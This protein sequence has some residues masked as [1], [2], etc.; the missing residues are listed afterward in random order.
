M[1]SVSVADAGAAGGG[2][3]GGGAVFA[4]GAEGA[5]G[6]AGAVAGVGTATGT[7]VGAGASARAAVGTA[8][9]ATAAACAGSVG[10]SAL[11]PP[12]EAP[13]DAVLQAIASAATPVIPATSMM[14]AGVFNM[15]V[16]PPIHRVD[17]HPV[18]PFPSYSR[19]AAEVVAP[20][21]GFL[22]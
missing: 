13:C 9:V 11:E 17:L 7:S 20:Q 19:G 10:L 12:D 22:S 6:S 18:S 1:S 16:V 21:D 5:G 3:G 15:A 2:G 14:D 4:G 8:W